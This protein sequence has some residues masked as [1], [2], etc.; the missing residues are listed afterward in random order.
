MGREGGFEMVGLLW[1][2][3]VFAAVVLRD[4]CGGRFDGTVWR[5]GGDGRERR[6]RGG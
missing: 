2:K 5:M 1:L 6:E 3:L 4:S